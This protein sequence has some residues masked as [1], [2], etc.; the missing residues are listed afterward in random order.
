DV[1]SSDLRYYQLAAAGAAHCTDCTPRVAALAFAGGELCE[2]AADPDCT[3][4]CAEQ[5]RCRAEGGR[6][7]AVDGDSCERSEACRQLGH[8]SYGGVHC[9]VGSDADCQGARVCHQDR[10]STRLNSSHVKISYAV[11]CLKK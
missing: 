11:F 1:C 8:C 4:A 3:E 6:C 5:G 10:K 2:S 7:V 9:A